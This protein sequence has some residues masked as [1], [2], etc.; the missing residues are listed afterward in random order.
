MTVLLVLIT[1]IGFLTIDY[2]YS[3]GK[4]T[5]VQVAPAVTK[6][7]VVRPLEPS[8][9]G[10]FKVPEALRYHPGHTWALS[11]LSLIHISNNL[12]SNE[13]F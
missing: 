6:H 9:V 13:F 8:L 10:G 5:V 7:N 3:R 11:E 4:Q 12:H 2:F 1:F